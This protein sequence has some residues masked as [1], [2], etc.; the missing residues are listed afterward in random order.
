MGYLR[1][2]HYRS[3]IVDINIITASSTSLLRFILR[4]DQLKIC[5]S[6]VAERSRFGTTRIVL[7]SLFLILFLSLSLS[8]FLSFNR[9]TYKYLLSFSFSVR[10][11]T[12]FKV[13][14]TWNNARGSNFR[15]IVHHAITSVFVALLILQFINSLVT[16]YLFAT[17]SFHSLVSISFIYHLFSCKHDTFLNTTR[18]WREYKPFDDRSTVAS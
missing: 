1:S 10:R 12:T 16:T 17:P 3:T 11:L 18:S 2:L 6:S 8:L 7:L 14:A 13:S 4:F 9:S 15:N 5:R